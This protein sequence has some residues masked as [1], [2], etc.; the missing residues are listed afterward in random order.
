MSQSHLANHGLKALMDH[1]GC[2]DASLAKAAGVDATTVDSWVRGESMPPPSNA[3]RAAEALDCDPQDLWP[4]IFPTMEPPST[5]TA[6]VSVYARRADMPASAWTSFFNKAAKAIDILVYSGTFLFE[7]V[8]RFAKT[9][10]NAASDGA[11]IRFL[12]GDPTTST[13]ELHGLDEQSDKELTGRRRMTFS[14]V[15]ALA[16]IDGLSVRV[17]N[18][19]AYTPLFRADDTLIT[20]PHLYGAPAS[21]NPAILIRREDTPDLWHNYQQTFERAWNDARSITSTDK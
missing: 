15:R 6:A 18:N 9:L 7:N 3:R 17:H 10:S 2:D 20:T 14:R 12:T 1:Q 8:P 19:P 13:A 16:N 11:Q 5:G 4:D 21:N